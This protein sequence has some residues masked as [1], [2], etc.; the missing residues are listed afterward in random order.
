MTNFCKIEVWRL[1][2]LAMWW[3]KVRDKTLV[4]YGW[5]CTNCGK[6]GYTYGAKTALD[7][8]YDHV[9]RGDWR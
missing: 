3:H 5:S 1:S 9:S 6:V 2:R 4:Q 7:A 8:A